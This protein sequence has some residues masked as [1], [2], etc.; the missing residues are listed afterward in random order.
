MKDCSP[1]IA[2]IIKGDKFSLNQ[3]PNSDLEKKQMQN[4]PYAFVVGSLMYTLVCTRIDIS[5]VVG[6]LGRYQSYPGLED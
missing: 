4:I 5:Y 1:S 3:C 2:P 6:M